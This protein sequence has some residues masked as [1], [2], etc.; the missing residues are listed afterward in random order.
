MKD[1]KF[2]S[3]SIFESAPRITKIL[4]KKENYYILIKQ[5]LI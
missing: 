5:Y 4:D 2:K 1:L 3:K